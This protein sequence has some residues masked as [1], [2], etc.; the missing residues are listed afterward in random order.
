MAESGE[1]T[2]R[3]AFESAQDE[4]DH[5]TELVKLLAP[6]AT[7]ALVL[8]QRQV[9]NGLAKAA[10]HGTYQDDEARTRIADTVD[11]LLSTMR[12]DLALE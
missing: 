8:Q 7:A 1:P 6:S 11:P 10:L 3:A 4:Y 9:F 12:Q 2:A 5:A